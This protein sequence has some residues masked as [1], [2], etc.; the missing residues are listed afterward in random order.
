MSTSIDDD[1]SL[2]PFSCSTCLQ[3]LPDECV[4]GSTWRISA[5]KDCGD[6]VI[7]PKDIPSS[8]R[9][10]SDWTG[11]KIK[12]DSLNNQHESFDM[13]QCH[14]E[15]EMKHESN[16]SSSATTQPRAPN[17]PAAFLHSLSH[18]TC[19]LSRG[20]SNSASALDRILAGL[21]QRLAWEPLSELAQRDPD[22]AEFLRTVAQTFVDATM[23]AAESKREVNDES[24][25]AHQ[26]LRITLAERLLSAIQLSSFLSSDLLTHECSQV[27]LLLIAAVNHSCVPN[28]ILGGDTLRSSKDIT[29][30]DQICISYLTKEQLKLNVLQRRSILKKSWGFNCKCMRCMVEQDG[31]TLVAGSASSENS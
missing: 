18:L 30:G 21:V 19:I 29:Q 14:Q 8:T 28:A 1:P 22:Q 6:G 3:I 26:S 5:I 20:M 24:I 2:V 4:C 27:T 31:G 7:A 16:T 25:N 12:I 23:T 13:D 9:I 17:L 10:I 11:F 15:N